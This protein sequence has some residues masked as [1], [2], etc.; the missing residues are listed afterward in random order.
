REVA[1]HRLEGDVRLALRRALPVNDRLALPESRVRRYEGSRRTS[2]LRKLVFAN[3]LWNTAFVVQ[4]LSEMVGITHIHEALPP[5]FKWV[6]LIALA[7]G[8]LVI[9]LMM[10]RRATD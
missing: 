9:H 1:H 8:N 6:W 10:L 5:E 3:M 2:P 7:G 4:G